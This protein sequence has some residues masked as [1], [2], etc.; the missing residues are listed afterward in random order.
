MTQVRDRNWKLAVPQLAQQFCSRGEETAGLFV[1]GET[2]GDLT[3]EHHVMELSTRQSRVAAVLIAIPANDCQVMGQLDA[4]GRIALD[5]DIPAG[6]VRGWIRAA[7]RSAPGLHVTWHPRRRG[8]DALPAPSGAGELR[9]ALE[10][11]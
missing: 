10:G 8:P 11:G 2:V 5:L 6:T 4:I 1:T 3:E 7:R 9:F